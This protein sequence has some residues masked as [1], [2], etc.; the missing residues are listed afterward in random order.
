LIL[1][2]IDHDIS[3]YGTHAMSWHH[4]LDTAELAVGDCKSASVR[5]I[6]IALFNL[7]GTVFA[8]GNICSHAQAFLT[9]GYID[10]DCIECPLH[11]ALFHIPS[12][13]VRSGPTEEPIPVYPAKV[14]GTSILVEIPDD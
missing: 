4:V 13:E 12:G 11:Q 1:A 2:N 3:Q 5:G 9:D 14:E 6:E 10:G 8:T 7:A